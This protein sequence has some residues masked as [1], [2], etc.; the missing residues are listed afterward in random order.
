M[1]SVSNWIFILTVAKLNTSNPLFVKC[2]KNYCSEKAY[3][4]DVDDDEIMDSTFPIRKQKKNHEVFIKSIR[5]CT[6]QI[7]K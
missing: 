4:H 6:Q 2:I 5:S 3:K 7:W 1:P